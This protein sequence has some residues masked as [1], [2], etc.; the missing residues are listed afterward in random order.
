MIIN[1]IIK[2][3]I[4]YFKL[5]KIQEDEFE[6]YCN[7]FHSLFDKDENLKIIFDLSELC[8]NDFLFTKQTLEFMKN[9]YYNTEKYIDKTAII[10]ENE[11]IKNLINVVILSVYKPIKPN[12]ITN[13]FNEA[14][15]FVK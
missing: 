7:Y 12:L 6:N 3:N 14:L 10:I 9:N 4:Y 13:T 5:S 1:K 11:V 15:L 2:N 8:M